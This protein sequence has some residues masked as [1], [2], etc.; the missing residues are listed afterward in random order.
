MVWFRERV[1][2]GGAFQRFSSD[3]NDDDGIPDVTKFQFGPIYKIGDEIRDEGKKPRVV[4]V[5][6]V[7]LI[8][9]LIAGFRRRNESERDRG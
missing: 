2:I 5:G 6:H 1:G 7:Q 4:I 3:G 8:F 9:E